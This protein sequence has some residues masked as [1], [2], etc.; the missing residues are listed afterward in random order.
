MINVLILNILPIL[1]LIVCGFSILQ[2]VNNKVRISLIYDLPYSFIVGIVFLYI[3]AFP[4]VRFDMLIGAW[5]LIIYCI[6]FIGFIYAIYIYKNAKSNNHKNL[7]FNWWYLLLSIVVIFLCVILYINIINPVVDSDAV[8][9]YRHIGLAKYIFWNYPLVETNAY[10]AGVSTTLSPPIF[11]AFI[12]MLQDRWYDSVAT[13]HYIFILVWSLLLAFFIGIRH[14]LS[15]KLSII[16]PLALISIPIIQ[17]HVIRP[18]YVDIIVMMFLMFVVSILLDIIR[19]KKINK[20]NLILIFFGIIGL[21]FSKIESLIWSSWVIV[22]LFSLYLYYHKNINWQK[23][24]FTQGI[25]FIVVFSL[26]LFYADWIYHNVNL[27]HRLSWLFDLQYNPASF[28]RFFSYVFSSGGQ[29]LI[30]WIFI[31]TSGLIVLKSKN[32]TYKVIILYAWILLLGVFHFSNFT[33]N[34]TFTLQGTNVGR[35][36]LQLTPLAILSYY[37]FIMSLNN[38]KLESIIKNRKK[39]IRKSHANYK[40]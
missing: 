33:F 9:N 34:I 12:N 30:W 39:R 37:L 24:L 13:T 28:D 14:N 31:V 19:D 1:F 18:G 5:H 15:I 17:V 25:L 32:T 40:K 4:L 2:I 38:H 6:G 3:I 26:Y 23:I 11:H 29:G 16:T 21:L 35:F 10:K 8:S 36:L 7:G 22:V 20:Y 27:P